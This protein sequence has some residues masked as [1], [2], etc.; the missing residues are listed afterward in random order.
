MKKGSPCIQQARM[1]GDFLWFDCGLLLHAANGNAR[2]DV[3]GQA[4]V[5]DQ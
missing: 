5:H 3:L 1:Q 2:D 4:E